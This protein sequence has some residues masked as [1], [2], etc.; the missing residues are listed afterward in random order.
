M[1]QLKG[2]RWCYKLKVSLIENCKAYH[3]KIH[4]IKGGCWHYK[5]TVCSKVAKS[6][7]QKYAKPGWALALHTY[8]VLEACQVYDAKI[9]SLKRERWRYKRTVCP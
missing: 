9:Q 4:K 7:V 5:H 8:C 6:T 1:Q 3:T 2:G